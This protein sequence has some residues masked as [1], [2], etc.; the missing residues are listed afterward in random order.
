MKTV[1]LVKRNDDW[2]LDEEV[3]KGLETT[4]CFLLRTPH[5]RNKFAPQKYGKPLPISKQDLLGEIFYILFSAKELGISFTQAVQGISMIK[6]RPA[7]TA[8]LMLALV[9]RS[10]LMTSF[11]E[12]LSGSLKSKD[13]KYTCTVQRGTLEKVVRSFS[14]EDA[15]RAGLWVYDD[16]EAKFL[17][18]KT[19][20][21][22]MLQMRARTTALRDTFPDVLKGFTSEEEAQ[23]IP[24]DVTPRPIP[25][26]DEQLLKLENQIPKIENY[27]SEKEIV[28]V[29]ELKEVSTA[30]KA[31]V[32]I[33][34][35]KMFKGEQYVVTP[36]G[37]YHLS[38]GIVYTKLDLADMASMN[39]NE[40]KRMYNRK[41]AEE[42]PIENKFPKELKGEIIDENVTVA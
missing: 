4:G 1:D 41:L 23:D 34:D 9:Y 35:S 13:A 42:N 16:A 26:L 36:D 29:P 17:P 2:M 18:W 7:L 31:P 5:V 24:I 3:L 20:P 25:N 15:T 33:H 28:E 6:G 12:V 21:L 27:V 11:V 14:I 40:K 8:E 38:S 10:K 22:R 37:S 32:T 39:E 19:Y 30:P